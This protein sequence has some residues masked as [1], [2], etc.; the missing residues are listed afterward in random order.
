[1]GSWATCCEITRERLQKLY[2]QK[3]DVLVLKEHQKSTGVVYTGIVFKDDNE[4]GEFDEG[5][6]GVPDV[7]VSD[8]LNVVKSNRMGKYKFHQEGNRQ[9]R[10]IF[11]TTPSG[12]SC[13][14]EFFARVYTSSKIKFD[15]GITEDSQSANPDFS[16]I[17]VGDSETCGMGKWLQEIKACIPFSKPAFIVHTGDIQRKA[18]IETHKRFMNKKT[19]GVPVYY[20]IG[21]HDYI[22]G[23]EFGEKIFEDNLGPVYYSLDYG[24]RHFVFLA[25]GPRSIDGNSQR[26]GLFTEQFEWLKN[27][28][29]HIPVDTEVIIFKH[30]P[31]WERW[32]SQGYDK[33]INT[34][35]RKLIAYIS[36]HWHSH[37][38]RYSKDG[39]LAVTTTPPNKGG[40]DNSPRCFRI[41]TFSKGKLSVNSRIGNQRYKVTIVSPIPDSEVS[42]HKDS[43]V[44][45]LANV[46]HTSCKVKEVSYRISE[47]GNATGW[48]SM[49]AKGEWSW[50]A[51]WMPEGGMDGQSKKQII[52]KAVFYDGKVLEKNADFTLSIPS[53]GL[54]IPKD[55][56]P[57]FLKNPIHHAIADSVIKPPL[58]L[59][60]VAH[61]GKNIGFSSPVVKKGKVFIGTLDDDNAVEQSVV[62]FD[63]R[64]GKELWRFIPDSSIKHTLAVDKN[65]VFATSVDGV[66]YALDIDNGRLV[67][68]RNLA[69]HHMGI[70]AGN[71]VA[72]EILYAGYADSFHALDAGTGKVLWK[73]KKWCGGYSSFIT[74]TIAD[75]VVYVGPHGCGSGKRGLCAYNAKTGELLWDKGKAG[76]NFL[77]C[78]PVVLENR[79]YTFIQGNLTVISSC[80]GKGF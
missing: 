25:M 5:E 18:G 76:G 4:N 66:V 22:P 33:V 57:M 42:Y 53:E 65:L 40:R 48:H 20:V 67:W 27:D 58:K 28:L 44:P 70:Y 45:I 13:T 78:A 52:V 41:F 8:G 31:L 69:S 62:A 36:G 50:M 80:C 55:D 46:Y 17:Q 73:N 2:T 74:P 11:I 35:Q 7:M 30:D 19:M 43:K 37:Q 9:P 64:T 15:F 51:E 77:N 49:V 16:F 3:P 38:A 12:Y 29:S 10:F 75:G 56:W 6:K 23:I 61:A 68:K 47:D 21:N 1:M 54:P 59:A 72:D 26:P 24:S 14:T 63:S 71:T 32:H 34:S 60:W 79:V 39:V